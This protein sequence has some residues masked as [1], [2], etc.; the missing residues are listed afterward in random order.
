MREPDLRVR[1]RPGG[2]HDARINPVWSGGRT[3]KRRSAGVGT[4]HGV[5]GRLMASTAT[6]SSLVGAVSAVGGT[7]GAR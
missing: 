4:C 2:V 1:V 5:C 7:R 3:W 6:R